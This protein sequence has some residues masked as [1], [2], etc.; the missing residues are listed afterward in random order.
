MSAQGVVVK[1]FE[2]RPP[3]WVFANPA[4]WL[5]EF[6]VGKGE[7]KVVYQFLV[8]AGRFGAGQTI[9]VEVYV[10]SDCGGEGSVALV[11]GQDKWNWTLFS[12]RSGGVLLPIPEEKNPWCYLV[13]TCEEPQQSAQRSRQRKSF[14]RYLLEDCP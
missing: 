14:R 8:P 5:G 2:P 12:C 3:D 9:G 4:C 7:T 13:V 6:T 11:H 10:M 1:V